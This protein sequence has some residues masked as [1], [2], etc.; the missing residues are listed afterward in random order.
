MRNL[1]FAHKIYYSIYPQ[2]LVQALGRLLDK[3]LEESIPGLL[4]LKFRSIQMSISMSIT[5]ISLRA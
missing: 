1:A 3:K 5:N 4:L 2:Y